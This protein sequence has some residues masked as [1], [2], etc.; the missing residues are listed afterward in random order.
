MTTA[1][2]AKLQYEAG[3]DSVAMSALTNSGDETVFTSSKSLWSGK[4]GF[5]PVVRPNGLLTGGAVTVDN[6]AAN[7]VVDIAALTCNLAG[8]VTS[9]AAGSL[10]ATRPATAV[11][12]V[13]SLTV[14]S[15]GALAAVAGTDGSTT[16]FSETRAAA[17]GPPL[18][19]TGSIEIGQ[20]RFTSDTAAPVASS[21]IFQVVGLHTER[22]D[23]PLYDVNYSSGSVTFLSALPEIHTGP[24]P[25]AVYA[26]YAGPI[27]ADVALASDFVPPETSNSV[28]S[29]Q[30]Y[31]TT[32]GASSSTLNQGTFTAYLTNGISDA[33][34]SLKNA[35]LWF[36]FF[37]DRYASPYLLCQG[38]LGI[39]RTFPVADQIQAACTISASAAAT[40][41]A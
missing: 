39:G 19:P 26:S 34:V 38:K 16:A 41:V 3:Q 24:V 8:V 12:K 32:I 35:T 5:A 4:S 15:S 21:E 20:V 37:P 11:S 2:D 7:N 31:G 29:T 36:K 33:L 13:I 18:I 27:F 40:E 22:A 9:V 1:A 10:T 14:N 28:T 17:G 6:A 30:V 23:F 25:K